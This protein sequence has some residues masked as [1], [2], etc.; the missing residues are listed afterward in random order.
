MSNDSLTIH[1][2]YMTQ[3]TN[4]ISGPLLLAS[5]CLIFPLQARMLYER[6]R[7]QCHSESDAL[8]ARPSA[9]PY[10]ILEILG[11]YNQLI[12]R[13]QVHTRH[14]VY[15]AYTVQNF[16][17]VECAYADRGQVF[18]LTE[19]GTIN[20][21]GPIVIVYD[22]FVTL[23]L[24]RT[25]CLSDM[26]DVMGVAV[27]LG[28]RFNLVHAIPNNSPPMTT[29]RR[30]HVCMQGHRYASYVRCHN[31]FLRNERGHIAIKAGGLMARLAVGTVN[32]NNIYNSAIAGGDR[33]IAMFGCLLYLPMFKEAVL[34][35][36]DTRHLGG[37]WQ[38]QLEQ[39]AVDRAPTKTEWRERLCPVLA[40]SRHLMDGCC[41]HAY[42]FMTER[43]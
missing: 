6:Y 13:D 24:Y 9:S 39:N 2:C 21:R 28:A 36:A 12:D 37:L 20:T 34:M 43:M 18:I 23:A 19:Y 33:K 31:V 7:F 27:R 22:P 5:G 25:A 40:A 11:C 16:K 3:T 35:V 30:K 29:C 8:P 4:A 10:A 38:D 17:F 41:K 15:I 42:R 32:P 14:D 1:M 26:R